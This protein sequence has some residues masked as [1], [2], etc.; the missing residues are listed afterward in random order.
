MS[1]LIL[2][3]FD[4]LLI[5]HGQKLF[6]NGCP[7]TGMVSTDVP[8]SEILKMCWSINFLRLHAMNNP[9]FQ[10]R[11]KDAP[12]MCD[13]IKWGGKMFRVREI[14]SQLGIATVRARRVYLRKSK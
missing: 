5:F 11:E 8:I 2:D 6:I 14:D 9:Q 10:F 3:G 1:A 7:K 4:R 12:R 13:L